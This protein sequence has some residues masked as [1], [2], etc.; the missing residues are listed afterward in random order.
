MTLRR[1]RRKDASASKA[2]LRALEMT[3]KI[4][5]APPRIFPAVIEELGA[6][7]GEAPALIGPER[8][9]YPCRSWR[10]APTASALGAG[11]RISKKATRVCLLMPNRP[12]YLAIWLGLTR[13][14]GVVALMNTNLTGEA[15]AHCIKRGRAHA[16]S[17]PRR[18]C[19]TPWA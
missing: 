10:R 16:I 11:R 3:A 13:I 2:W 7:F 6:R 1:W 5:D 19:W 17:S 9:I 4:D 15:L 18:V 14:G 8:N 12:D